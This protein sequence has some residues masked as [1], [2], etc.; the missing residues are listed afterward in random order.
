M[1]YKIYQLS[2]IYLYN[3]FHIVVISPFEYPLITEYI[4]SYFQA[5]LLLIIINEHFIHSVYFTQTHLHNKKLSSS[6]TLYKN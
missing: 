4:T 2:S 5:D 6:Y 3:I 1:N